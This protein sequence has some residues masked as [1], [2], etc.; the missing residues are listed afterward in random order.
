MD[1][2][3]TDGCF[4]IPSSNLERRGGDDCLGNITSVENSSIGLVIIGF[5]VTVFGEFRMVGCLTRFRFINV[6]I[7]PTT[8]HITIQPRRIAR[9]DVP[10]IIPDDSFFA[11]SCAATSAAAHT[12]RKSVAVLVAVAVAD[13]LDETVS[14]TLAVALLEDV[15][16]LV[17][18]LLT[19]AV[20]EPLTEALSLAVAVQDG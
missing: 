15:I 4:R 1:T 7:P 17:A 6:Y 14:D 5:R 3:R 2:D 11:E 12:G 19:E 10:D 18:V 13:P 20:A 9:I 8:A 16:D